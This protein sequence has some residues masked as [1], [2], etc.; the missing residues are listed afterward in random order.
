VGKLLYLRVDSVSAAVGTTITARDSAG[1]QVKVWTL[2]SQ[3]LGKGA[4]PLVKGTQ[5]AVKEPFYGKSPKGEY[6]VR[7]DH[8]TDA[9]LVVPEP[10]SLDGYLSGGNAAFL[11]GRY[12][13]ATEW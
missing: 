10:P 7:L 13:E 2:I 8:P 6:C 12:L 11:K 4:G 3:P 9:R 1:A 5:I